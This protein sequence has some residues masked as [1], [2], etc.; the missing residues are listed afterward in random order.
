VFVMRPVSI[1][2]KQIVDLVTTSREAVIAG[3]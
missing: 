1:S 2:A 3:L